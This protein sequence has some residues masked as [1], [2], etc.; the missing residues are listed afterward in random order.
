MW[1]EILKVVAG[2]SSVAFRYLTCG[3]VNLLVFKKEHMNEESD[4]EDLSDYEIKDKP[5]ASRLVGFEVK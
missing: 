1:V 5:T 3:S 2:K 4:D